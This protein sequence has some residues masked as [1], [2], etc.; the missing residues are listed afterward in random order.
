MTEDKRKQYYQ[1]NKEKLRQ[2]AVEYYHKKKTEDPLFYEMILKRNNE[3][4]HKV[5]CLE[6]N[7]AEDELQMQQ[8]IEWARRVNNDNVFLK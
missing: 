3:Y 4:Y 7:P 6:T 5:K 8:I 1:L 2:K